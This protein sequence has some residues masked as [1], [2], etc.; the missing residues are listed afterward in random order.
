MPLLFREAEGT[1][2]TASQTLN[3]CLRY[4]SRDFSAATAALLASTCRAASTSSEARSQSHRTEVSSDKSAGKNFAD[5]L[6]DLDRSTRI[7]RE[8]HRRTR[9]FCEIYSSTNG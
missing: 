3:Q 9:I 7:F 6:C 2:A 1:A 8:I 5:K 4:R